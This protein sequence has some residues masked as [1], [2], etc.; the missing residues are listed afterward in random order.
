MGVASPSILDSLECN[1]VQVSRNFATTMAADE[2]MEQ[3][4][5]ERIKE[6]GNN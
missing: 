5:N 3:E 4:S 2:G 1:E 6:R